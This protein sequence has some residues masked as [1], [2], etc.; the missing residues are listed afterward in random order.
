[1]AYDVRRRLPIAELTST[2]SVVKD[3]V[4]IR[5]RFRQDMQDHARPSTIHFDN[6]DTP[7]CRFA[8]DSSTL[9]DC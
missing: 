6:R 8:T 3:V 9:D 2:H 5:A 4:A 7:C 1:M